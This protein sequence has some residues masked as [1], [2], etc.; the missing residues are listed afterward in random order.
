[1]GLIGA[2]L[3]SAVGGLAGLLAGPAPVMKRAN[4]NNQV[5]LDEMKAR[6]ER[7]AGELERMRMEGTE[8]AAI[9][10]GTPEQAKIEQTALGGANGADVSDALSRRSQKNF[11]HDISKLQRQAKVDSVN[12]HYEQVQTSAAMNSAKSQMDEYQRAAEQQA[13]REQ[14]AARYSVLS[15]VLQG[16]GQWAGMG[17]AGMKPSGNSMDMQIQEGVAAGP[18]KPGQRAYGF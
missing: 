3:G 11:G 1:M 14:D 12:D 18:P 4:F 10:Q 17:V 2:G 9:M 13:G 5:D 8:G 7:G 15:S 16:V 6:S